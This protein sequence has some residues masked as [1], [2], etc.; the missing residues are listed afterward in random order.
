MCA[1]TETDVRESAND[2]TLASGEGQGSRGETLHSICAASPVSSSAERTVYLQLNPCSH[3]P[4][5]TSSMPRGRVCLLRICSAFCQE[6]VLH[7]QHITDN[8]SFCTIYKSSQS[9][10]CKADHA[11]LT[12][13]ML[14]WQLGHL[15]GCKLDHRQVKLLIFLL[16]CSKSKP[17]YDW[18]F[19]ANLFVLASSLFRHTTRVLFSWTLAVIVL[20]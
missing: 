1:C 16:E 5:V 3:G 2:C 18:R 15:N 11:H 13:L 10:L 14:Q 8:P 19:T 6:Y 9:W 12:Y 4:Y 20:I 7:I 17:L